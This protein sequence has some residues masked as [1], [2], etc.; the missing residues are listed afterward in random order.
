MT[1]VNQTSTRSS[2]REES[3]ASLVVVARFG[4]NKIRVEFRHTVTL[5]ERDNPTSTLL[6]IC[7]M[8][9]C[10][11]SSTCALLNKMTVASITF[12]K[13]L[14]CFVGMF[15]TWRMKMRVKLIRLLFWDWLF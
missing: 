10:E 11:K 3:H 8:I 14:H 12:S 7:S 9:D 13:C 6:T 1:S 5:L 4:G 2:R 15:V